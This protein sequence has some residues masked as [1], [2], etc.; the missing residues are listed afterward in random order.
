MYGEEKVRATLGVRVDLMH[1]IYL[2][3]LTFDPDGRNCVL[4]MLPLTKKR[5]KLFSPISPLANVK[6]GK[7]LKT[8]YIHNYQIPL[9]RRPSPHLQM[10]R[11]MALANL[12]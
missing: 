1:F 4:Q 12:G 5:K 2:A 3:E 7:E 9:R 11:L 8:Y 6:Y 10:C